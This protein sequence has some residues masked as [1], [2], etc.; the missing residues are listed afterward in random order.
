MPESMSNHADT[1]ERLVEALGQLAV[2]E[3]RLRA[4]VMVAKE[5][6]AVR[7]DE[8]CGH[9]MMVL[10]KARELLEPECQRDLVGTDCRCPACEERRVEAAEYARESMED[11]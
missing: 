8:W 3:Q 11:R 6:L 5:E 7:S 10:D 2:T 4:L 1:M 9:S